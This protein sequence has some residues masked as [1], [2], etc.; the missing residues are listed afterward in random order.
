[1]ISDRGIASRL[2]NFGID[3]VT[4]FDRSTEQTTNMQNSVGIFLRISNRKLG[5]RR[6]SE[7]TG[8]AY[9]TTRLCIKRCVVEHNHSDGVF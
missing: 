6:S 5:T 4:N 1:M 3:A 8:I 9:L 2:F 7:H